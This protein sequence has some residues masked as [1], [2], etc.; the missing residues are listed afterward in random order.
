MDEGQ[1][2]NFHDANHYAWN[3]DSGVAAKNEVWSSELN[4]T[5]TL[6]S[7]N[8]ETSSFDVTMEGGGARSHADR[9]SRYRY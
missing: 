4:N 5:R 8:L 2:E 6:R 1:A 3:G 9:Y 7:R